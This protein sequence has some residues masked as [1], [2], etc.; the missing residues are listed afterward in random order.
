MAAFGLPDGVGISLT[1]SEQSNYEARRESF[2]RRD[3]YVLGV[4]GGAL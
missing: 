3:G 1:D 2:Q 4:C